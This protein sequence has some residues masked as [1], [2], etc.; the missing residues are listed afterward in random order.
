E[1]TLKKAKWQYIMVIM[2]VDTKTKKIVAIVLI[3]VFLCAAVGVSIWLIVV[4][5]QSRECNLIKID[6]S[7]APKP[8]DVNSCTEHYIQLS[9]VNMFYVVYGEGSGKKPLILIHGNAR[10]HHALEE[11]A[12]YFANDYTVYVTDSRCHGKSTKLDKINYD[13]MAKDMM[14]FITALGLDHPYVVGHS[15]GGIT[16]LAMA[17]NY[18]DLMGGF[19]AAG[20][21]STP[22]S[23]KSYFTTTINLQYKRSNSPVDLMM[24]EEPKFTREQLASIT[25][26]AFIVAGE[27]DIVK[28]YDTKYMAETIPNAKVAIIKWAGHS[29]YMTANGKKCYCLAQT[30]FKT[31]E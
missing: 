1:L 30:F 3:A 28:L 26:P 8:V 24:I 29:T 27:F 5:V 21:N 20:A 14:E 11:A 13:I 6:T 2:K 19:M 18:P 10:D 16:A 31:L 4:D 12:T 22:A 15:D 23:F 9:E 17:I 25:T 7:N